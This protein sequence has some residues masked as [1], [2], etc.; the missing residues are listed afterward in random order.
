MKI[1]TI[2]IFH[3]DVYIYCGSTMCSDE[4]GNVVIYSLN[5]SIHVYVHEDLHEIYL[6]NVKG[7]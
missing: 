4:A 5:T 3:E 2:L 1:D 6:Y 7:Q